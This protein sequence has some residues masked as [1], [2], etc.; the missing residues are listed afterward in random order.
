ML[1]AAMLRIGRSPAM[2][3]ACAVREAQAQAREQAR[4]YA[5]RIWAEAYLAGA[6]YGLA[7]NTQPIRV[8][9]TGPG[10][11]DFMRSLAKADDKP[12]R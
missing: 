11:D 6:A 4:L 12:G 9:L 5:D 10:A 7:R 3:D 1:A 2:S 8:E